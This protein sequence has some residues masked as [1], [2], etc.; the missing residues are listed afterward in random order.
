MKTLEKAKA[1]K[2]IAPDTSALFLALKKETKKK[3]KV[4]SA[5]QDLSMTEIIETLINKN[6]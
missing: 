1:S 2:T 4:A 5:V 6:L 3:L